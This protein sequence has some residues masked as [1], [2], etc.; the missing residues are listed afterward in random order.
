MCFK[1]V[2]NAYAI[3]VVEAAVSNRHAGMKSLYNRACGI[4]SPNK[5]MWLWDVD[6]IDE[7]TLITES[8]LKHNEVWYA[9]IPSK[10]G[11]HYITKP[12]DVS[13]FYYNQKKIQIH[14]DNPTNLY[15]PD[16]AE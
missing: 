13:K 4:I 3:M 9:T 5:K 16:D 1:K 15:I 6:T 8:I 12:I 10:K 11:L 14:R 7:E 2:G